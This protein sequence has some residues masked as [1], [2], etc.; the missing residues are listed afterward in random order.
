MTKSVKDID[1]PESCVCG[2]PNTERIIST[3]QFFYGAS[4]WDK[5]H[6]SP[7]LGRVVRN[8]LEARRL[9]KERGLVEVGN[10]PVERIHSHYDKGRAE[11]AER[12]YQDIV[13]D[14]LNLGEVSCE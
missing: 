13:D 1:H 4:D 6:Y 12:N 8:N 9:A 7:A 5:S 11:K 2:S 10:E 3:R 14:A